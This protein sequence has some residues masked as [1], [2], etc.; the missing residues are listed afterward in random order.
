MGQCDLAQMAFPPFVMEGEVVS[1]DP[2]GVF[3]TYQLKRKLLYKW[4]VFI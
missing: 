4:M 3:V 1:Q 2:L